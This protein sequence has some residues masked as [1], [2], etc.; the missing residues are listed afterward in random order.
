[1]RKKNNQ[2]QE[3]KINSQA[4]KTEKKTIIQKTIKSLSSLRFIVMENGSKQKT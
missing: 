2:T 1:M 4:T 3:P